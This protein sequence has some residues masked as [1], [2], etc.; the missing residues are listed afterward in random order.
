MKHNK[1]VADDHVMV[2]LWLGWIHGQPM[3][4]MWLEFSDPPKQYHFV[5]YNANEIE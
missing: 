1:N 5:D 3:I 4:N 2:R